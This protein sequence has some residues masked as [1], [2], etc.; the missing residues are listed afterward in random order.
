M[1][2]SKGQVSALDSDCQAT[3]LEPPQGGDCVVWGLNSEQHA[4]PY[5]SQAPM[6]APEC[7]PAYSESCRASWHPWEQDSEIPGDQKATI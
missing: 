1:E 2:S 4:T 3:S 5:M 7:H 6:L